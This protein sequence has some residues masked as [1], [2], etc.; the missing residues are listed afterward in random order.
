MTTNKI[1]IPTKTKMTQGRPPC[2]WGVLSFLGLIGLN[3]A[4]DGPHARANYGWYQE[5]V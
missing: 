4:I 5:S 2:T 3:L 1:A